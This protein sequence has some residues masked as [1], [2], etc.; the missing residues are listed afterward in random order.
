MITYFVSGDE[1]IEPSTTNL[2]A[3]GRAVRHGAEFGEEAV[4]ALAAGGRFVVV[5][6][7]DESGTVYFRPGVA[8]PQRRWLWVGMEPTPARTRVYLYCC[9]AGPEITKYLADCECLG[10]SDIVP[11]PAGPDYREALMFLDAVDAL[12]DEHEFRADPWR[13]QLQQFVAEQLDDALAVATEQNYR[14]VCVWK[15]LARSL[16]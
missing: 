1:D 16:A 7:G 11:I 12:M 9:K 8:E 2:R 14:P 15:M 10:H 5:A 4:A 6:H 3:T 13:Y